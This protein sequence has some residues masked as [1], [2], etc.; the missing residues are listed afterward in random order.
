MKNKN[1]FKP[2]TD[3]SPM[4]FGKFKGDKMENVPAKYLLWLYNNDKCFGL[5]KDYIIDNLQVLEQE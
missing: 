1:L 4:P 2:L 5:V 3:T